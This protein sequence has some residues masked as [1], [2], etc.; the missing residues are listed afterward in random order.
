M[1]GFTVVEPGGN[2]ANEA[3]RSILA[4]VAVGR[5]LRVQRL[6]R[7]GGFGRA[8]IHSMLS[9]AVDYH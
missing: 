1:P 4:A 5:Y 9:R 8:S 3:L 7:E 2:V 6:G